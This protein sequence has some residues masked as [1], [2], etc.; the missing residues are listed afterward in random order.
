MRKI[1]KK[2]YQNPSLMVIAI[3]ARQIICTSDPQPPTPV[4]PSNPV[5][6]DSGNYT[7][8]HNVW[9]DDWD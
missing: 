2:I 5:G 6:D 4:D 9:D 1:M 7:K 8:R 3:N